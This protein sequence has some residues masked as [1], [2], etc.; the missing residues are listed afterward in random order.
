[1]ALS[2]EQANQ[3]CFSLCLNQTISKIEDILKHNRRKEDIMSQYVRPN[4]LGVSFMF[5]VLCLRNID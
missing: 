5:S 4:L 3:Q 2:C 1:M